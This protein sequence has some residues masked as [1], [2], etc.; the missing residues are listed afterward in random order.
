MKK[1]VSLILMLALIMSFSACAQADITMQKI[2]DAN[3]TEGYVYDYIPDEASDWAEFMT[4][5]ASVISTVSPSSIP[6]S[7]EKSP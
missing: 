3:L 1:F 6:V 5:D 4:D 2:Y 7:T